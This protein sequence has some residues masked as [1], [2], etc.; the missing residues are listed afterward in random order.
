MA[1]KTTG[2]GKTHPRFW[3]LFFLIYPKSKYPIVKNNIILQVDNIVNE[4]L[5][6]SNKKK[7]KEK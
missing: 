3:E 7:K 4:R 1:K 6:S 5:G 2:W